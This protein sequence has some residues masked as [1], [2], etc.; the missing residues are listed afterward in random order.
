MFGFYFPRS[1]REDAYATAAAI[2]TDAG[3]MENDAPT[4]RWREIIE[5]GD[6]QLRE[7]M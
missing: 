1:G 3:L 6:S 2:A 5:A 7:S 4:D